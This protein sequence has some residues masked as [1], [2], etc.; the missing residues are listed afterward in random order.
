MVLVK[1]FVISSFLFYFDDV[2]WYPPV[3]LN[4]FQNALLKLEKIVNV[5]EQT[6]AGKI[7]YITLEA[8]DGDQKKVYEA[9]VWVKPWEKFKEVQ[10]FKP[11]ADAPST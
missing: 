6:V 3:I 9:K 10:W 7:Y 11:V 1:I 5:R 4:L 2:L 8:L